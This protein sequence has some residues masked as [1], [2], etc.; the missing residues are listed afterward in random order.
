[1]LRRHEAKH[2]TSCYARLWANCFITYPSMK[3]NIM[4]LHAAFPPVIIVVNKQ[5]F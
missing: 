3:V 1:M 2:R 4:A 5:S